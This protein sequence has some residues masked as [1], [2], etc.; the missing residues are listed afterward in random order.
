[1][2]TCTRLTNAPST[3]PFSP[4]ARCHWSSRRV[5]TGT[6]QCLRRPSTLHQ[7]RTPLSLFTIRHSPFSQPATPE[8]SSAENAS[9][10]LTKRTQKTPLATP[11][12]PIRPKKRTQTNPIKRQTNPKN[13]PNEPNQTHSCRRTDIARSQT[14]QNTPLP[15]TLSSSAPLSPGQ[16]M[17]PDHTAASRRTS[18]LGHATGRVVAVGHTRTTIPPDDQH[19]VGTSVRA[20]RRS[21]GDRGGGRVPHQL[22]WSRRRAVG[23]GNKM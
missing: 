19:R 20:E 5:G 12:T 7:S 6:R 11:K 22:V 9:F 23:Q 4:F 2:L 10:F 3:C 17:P 8:P 18:G 1:M 21:V 16:S 15:L 13:D 14:C